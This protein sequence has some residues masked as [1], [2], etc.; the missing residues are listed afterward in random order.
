MC[1]MLYLR[2]ADVDAVDAN[3]RTPMALAEAKNRADIYKVCCS[4]ASQYAT[5]CCYPV[6]ALAVQCAIL[7]CCFVLFCDQA[8]TKV[9]FFSPKEKEAFFALIDR[10]AEEAATSK[11]G[12]DK[13]DKADNDLPKTEEA[14]ESAGELLKKTYGGKDIFTTL[15]HP[16]TG[17]S[18]VQ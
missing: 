13:A 7:S 15:R 17:T 4:S 14:E 2:G 10:A 5:T 9:D 8:L 3:G 12:A 11:D 18:S 6:H 16:R 1:E